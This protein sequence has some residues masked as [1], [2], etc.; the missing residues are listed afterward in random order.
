RLP[1]AVL[2][3]GDHD[4]ALRIVPARKRLRDRADLL[5]EAQRELLAAG[6]EVDHGLL[7]VEAAGPADVDDLVAERADPACQVAR[8]VDVAAAVQHDDLDRPRRGQRGTGDLRGSGGRVVAVT[9]R[10]DDRRDEG[11]ER[12]GDP[13]QDGEP[14]PRVR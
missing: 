12:P 6:R 7:V 13:E 5:R 14:G 9:R 4:E 1:Q 11:A 3:A 8:V 10:E 2:W